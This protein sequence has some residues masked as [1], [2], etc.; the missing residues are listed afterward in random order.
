MDAV[1]ARGQP[2][3][4]VTA[5]TVGQGGGDIVA[6][7][8]PQL[9]CHVGEKNALLVI[10]VQFAIGIHIVKDGAT[11]GGD[12]AVG[13]V[14]EVLQQVEIAG[15]A[16]VR[17]GG[18]ISRNA[19]GIDAV[20]QA[21]PTIGQ[22]RAIDPDD[23]GCLHVDMAEG[24]G[25]FGIGR[26]P[27][28]GI[29]EIGRLKQLDAH[30]LKSLAGI[31]FSVAVAVEVNQVADQTRRADQPRDIGVGVHAIG[32]VAEVHAKLIRRAIDA[33]RGP[34]I[35]PG[36]GLQAVVEHPRQIR[37]ATRQRPVEQTLGIGDGDHVIT[38]L[39]PRE[40]IVPGGIRHGRGDD[41]LAGIPDV[42]AVG[43]PH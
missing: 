41:G 31:G 32:H 7:G 17:H 12:R 40:E 20:G 14:A 5:L 16:D 37:V 30:A 3:K 38:R 29:H 36:I 4:A 39:N 9:D 25:A 43:V 34:L 23:P 33:D 22:G 15:L 28:D 27:G 18:L 13:R 6:V 2:R 8:I 35:E 11:D 10:R 26:R 24:I 21:S 19:V 1:G 42:V